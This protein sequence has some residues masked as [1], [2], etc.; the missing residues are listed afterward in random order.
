MVFKECAYICCKVK[1][2]RSQYGICEIR[3]NEGVIDRIT[4]TNFIMKYRILEEK[5]LKVDAFMLSVWE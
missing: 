2:N 4:P 1:V 5:C 3:K